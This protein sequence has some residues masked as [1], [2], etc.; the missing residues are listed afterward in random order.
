MAVAGCGIGR[1]DYT[2]YSG[3]IVVGTTDKIY[4]I[5]PARAYDNGSL[6]VETQV[7]P[8]LLNF[9]PGKVIPEPD[10]ASSCSYTDPTTYTCHLRPNL[11]FANGDPLTARSV[12]FSFDRMVKIND[13]NGP[14]SLLGN[15]VST[16]I[17]DDGTVAFSLKLPHDQTFPMI[18]TT[19]AGPIVDEK[20]FPADKLMDDNAI[21][22]AEPFAGPYTI[23]SYAK[24]RL[25]EFRA[26]PG[27]TGLLGKPKNDIMV[28][29]FYVSSENLKMD[30]QNK[31]LD[32]GYRSFSPQDIESLRGSRKVKVH[33]GPGGELRYLVFNLKTMPGANP[34]QQLAVRKAVASLINRKAL[35]D[36][37][38]LGT[39]QPAYSMV[40]PGL[41]SASEAYGVTFGRTPDPQAAAKFLKDAG[42]P[43]P[44]NLQ[45][46]YN[47]DHYG[48]S[49]SEEYAAVKS[50]L[51]A[52]GLIR[53]NLQSTE[54]VSYND[55]RVKDSYPAFQLGWF[56]DYPDADDYL[57]PLFGPNN[58][59][60]NHFDSP[61]IN[62][63][64]AQET[65]EPD[66]VRRQAILRQL[67]DAL[68][69]DLPAVPLLTGEQLAVAGNDIHGVGD[70]LDA[71]FRFRF[72][73]LSKS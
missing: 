44:V 34:D 54:W 29:K 39:Y 18:L 5:D 33:T 21:V 14:A 15:L 26:N 46:Q 70:T 8:L 64:L 58:F 50:Q 59:T 31:A 13:P 9:A 19:Q 62:T 10:A 47:P 27:Y 6:T 41:P 40:P 30:L 4:A 1:T 7:Y 38:Y 52:T 12:K 24:N 67:Q 57:T 66:P 37:V 35:A 32:V 49:S 51:E 63:L 20:V 17:I 53:V 60:Q 42:V 55:E 36:D 56:P 23:A 48:G 28:E 71:S 65:G 3:A 61:E 22:A 45:L 2:D 72:G 11:H 43:T 68:T 73:S 16:N 69:K 25:V